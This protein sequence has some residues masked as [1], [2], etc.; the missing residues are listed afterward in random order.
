[1]LIPNGRLSP[2]TNG[3]NALTASTTDYSNQPGTRFVTENFPGVD[4]WVGEYTTLGRLKDPL[5][6]VARSRGHNPSRSLHL[7]ANGGQQR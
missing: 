3:I 2:T 6:P 4:Y 7:P 1:M 5:D